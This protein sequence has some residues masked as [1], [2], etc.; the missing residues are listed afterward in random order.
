MKK[1]N[2]AIIGA[3]DKPERYSY[4]AMQLLLKKGHN[5]FLISPKH[6]KIEGLPVYP[7]LKSIEEKIDTVTLYIS[8][9]LQDNKVIE[10]IVEKKPQ[11]VIFNPGTEN[12]SLVEILNAAKIA[13]EDACTLVLLNTDQF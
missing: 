8:A 11:R 10:D 12:I 2:V 9:S 4:K 13:N 3:S 1:Q 6:S 7:S 5:V